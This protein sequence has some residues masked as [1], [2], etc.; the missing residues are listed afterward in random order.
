MTPFPEFEARARALVGQMTLEEKASQMM[1]GAPAIERLGIP[2]YNWWNEALHGVARAGIATVFPQAIGM[3]AAWN[4]PLMHE[5]A[6]VIGDEARAKHHEAVRQGNTSIYTGLTLWSPNINIFRDPRWGRGQET[7]GEDP[8]LTARMGVAYVRALQGDHPKYL[9]AVATPKHYAVHSGP[10]G[11]R[12]SFDV[13]PTRRDLWETYLPAFEA[14]VREGQAASI[15]GAYNRLFGEP[16][17]ASPFLLQDILRDRWGFEGFVASDCGAIYNIYMFHK[18]VDT[19]AEAAAL[20]VNAGCDLEC[21]W[22]HVY[23]ALPEAVALGLITE[24]TIDTSLVRLLV[25]RMR[26]GM[27]DP[28]EQVPYAGI[29]FSVNDA[30]EHRALALRAARESMVLLKNQARTLPLSPQVRRIAVIGPNADEP[31]VLL[32]NYNGTPSS[33]VTPLAGI[34]A[35]A[36]VGAEVNYVRGCGLFAEDER[37]FAAAVE[38]AQQAD[39]VIFVAGLAQALEGEEGQVEGL[40]EGLKSQGDR[41]RIE[42]PD[43]QERLLHAVHATGIPVVLVL[44]NG[45]ALAVTWADAHLPAILEAWYPG[46]EGGTA[47]GEVLFGA[48]NPA[49]RLPVTFYRATA[50]LPDFEDYHMHGRTYRY[51]AG[52]ALYPFGHGLSYTTFDYSGLHVESAGTGGDTRVQVSATVRNTGDVAGDEVVQAYIS[53]GRDGYPLRQLAAFARVHVAPGQARDISFQLAAAQFQR[54]TDDGASV[55]ESGDFS[56]WVGGGQP[57]HADGLAG[58]VHIQA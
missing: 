30:P 52:E 31:E 38:A 54:V 35:L 41:L 15:M 47:I 56:V 25:G 9:K 44:L 3:A 32:G 34:R 37:E 57:G 14:T 45:S 49:G 18:V 2:A 43:I 11:T 58:S 17:C 40:P 24:E 21:Q 10:E 46:E 6:S 19:P 42:L 8:Y 13:S 28:P 27:F 26:L 55:L 5:V 50:D 1:H 48:Y 4:V 51:F 16:C 36:P 33:S 22:S 53:A 23:A 29:P 39:V 12:A 7:Y 20:A